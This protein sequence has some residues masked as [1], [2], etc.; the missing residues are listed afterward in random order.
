LVEII[1]KKKEEK[2]DVLYWINYV[3]EVGT[4]HLMTEEY[5]K[6]YPF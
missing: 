6:M 3:L 5:L 4:E 1:N 2:E